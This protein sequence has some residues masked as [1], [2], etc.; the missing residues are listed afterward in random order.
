MRGAGLYISVG[1]IAL[2]RAVSYRKVIQ[3]DK[4]MVSTRAWYVVQVPG[5]ETRTGTVP[6]R[7]AYFYYLN[8]YEI[9]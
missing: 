1:V 5:L 8:E 2:F 3:K 7:Y 9:I 4:V 6:G